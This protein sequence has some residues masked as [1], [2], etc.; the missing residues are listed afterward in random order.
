MDFSLIQTTVNLSKF[1]FSEISQ[2]SFTLLT[3]EM[4]RSET[5]IKTSDKS[6]SFGGACGGIEF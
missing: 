5:L 1:T 4:Q 3:I 2:E 6:H